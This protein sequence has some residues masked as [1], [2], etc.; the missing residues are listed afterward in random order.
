MS[1]SIRFARH[2]AGLAA[3]M[4]ATAVANAQDPG[5]T[6]KPL[7]AQFWEFHLKSPTQVM[8]K[9]KVTYRSNADGKE[10]EKEY[11]PADPKDGGPLVLVV[12]GTYALKLEPNHDPLSYEAEVVEL[13]EK[14]EV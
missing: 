1:G 13:D 6:V 7:D 9:L 12:P 2:G 11:T 8:K 14:P 3:L 10:V 5:A 4:L